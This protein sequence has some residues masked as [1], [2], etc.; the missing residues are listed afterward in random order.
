MSAPSLPDIDRFLAERRAQAQVERFGAFDAV[1]LS[2]LA[3]VPEWTESLASQ[4]KLLGDDSRALLDRL[5]G[6]DLIE[7]RETLRA[8]GQREQAFWVRSS[9]RMPLGRFLRDTRGTAVESDL[10]DLAAAIGRLDV[11]ASG[12]APWVEVVTEHRADPSGISLVRRVDRLAAAGDFGQAAELV[13]AARAVGEVTGGPLADAARRARWRIDRATRTAVDLRHLESYVPRAAFESAIDEVVLS[14][15]DPWALHLRGSGGVGKTMLVRYLACDRYARERELEPF[16]VARVDFDYLDPRYPEDRPGELLIALA[17][18][19]L[20]FGDTRTVGNAYRIFRD[21]VAELH[22]E[23]S[24]SQ[25]HDDHADDLLEQAI[26]AFARILHA[27]R[28]PSV[29]VLDTCEELTK[30]Y[31]PG[32]VAPAIDRTFWIL[33][34]LRVQ[35]D[36]L[37]VILAGRHWLTPPDDPARRAAGPLLRPR[38]YLRVVEVGG[39]DRKEAQAYIDLRERAHGARAGLD[40]PTAGRRLSPATRAVLLERAQLVHG[41]G[42]FNPFELASYCEWALTDPD[43]LGAVELGSSTQDPLVE[44]RVIGRISDDAVRQGAPIAAE[45]GRFDVDL[46]APAMARLHLDPEAIFAGLA[47]CEWVNVIAIGA[48]GRPSVLE[49]DEHLKD[50]I[51]AVTAR[52][53]SFPRV[54]RWQLGRDAANV[55]LAKRD[56]AATEVVEAAIRL[57][58]LKEADSFWRQV[59][60]NVAEDRAWGWA[61]NIAARAAAAEAQRADTAGAKTRTILGSILALE[62]AARMRLGRRDEVGALWDSVREVAGRHPDPTVAAELS[63][64]AVMGRIAAA[65][66]SAA[67]RL[68][69]WLAAAPKRSVLAALEGQLARAESPSPALVVWL[70]ALGTGEDL[71]LAAAEGLAETVVLLQQGRFDDAALTADDAMEVAGAATDQPETAWPDWEPPRRLLDRCR[72]ARLAVADRRGESVDRA[73]LAHWRDEALPHTNDV[74]AERLVSLCLRLELGQAMMDPNTLERIEASSFY[75]AD[76]RPT[77]WAHRCASPLGIEV[78]TAWGVLGDPLRAAALLRTYREAAVDAGDDADTVT[79]AELA[80]IALCRKYRTLRFLPSIRRLAR[81]GSPDVRAEAWFVLTLVEGMRPASPEEAGSWHAWWRCQDL[82]SLAKG[83]M[84]PP[85]EY[86]AP[87]RIATQDLFEYASLLG[88]FG[89]PDSMPS[90]EL[91][92]QPPSWLPGDHEEADARVTAPPAGSRG[93][94]L[95]ELGEEL[96]LRFPE[97]ASVILDRAAGC[98]RRAG[99]LRGSAQAGVLAGLAAIR[100]GREPSPSVGERTLALEPVVT[101]EGWEGWATRV[102][103]VRSHGRAFSL[104]K[105]SGSPEL[106][107]VAATSLSGRRNRLRLKTT[108]SLSRVL[109]AA[110]DNLT[111]LTSGLLLAVAS[112]PLGSYLWPGHD[113]PLTLVVALVSMVTG[114]SLS[115]IPWGDLS[116]SVG[117]ARS[118]RILATDR[119]TATLTADRHGGLWAFAKGSGLSARW[120]RAFGRKVRW[121]V[122][123]PVA[124]GEVIKPIGLRLPARPGT[125]SLVVVEL[126]VDPR[127]ESVSWEQRLGPGAPPVLRQSLLWI[128]RVPGRPRATDPKGWRHGAST[129]RGP[130]PLGPAVVLAKRAGRRARPARTPASRVIHLIGTP[131]RTAAGW[132]FRVGFTGLA[133][134][135]GSRRTAEGEELID[136][137]AL[138]LDQ[139][140]LLV[141]QAEPV[142]GLPQPFGHLREGFISLARVAV[143][144]GVIQAIVVPPL[145]DEA[146]AMVVET[147]WRRF[148]T[149]RIVPG[150]LGALALQSQIKR[151]VSERQTSDEKGAAVFDVVQF[152][153][154]HTANE[155][156]RDRERDVR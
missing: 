26:A 104:P 31:A 148:A 137:D 43:F 127:L 109:A 99:D 125:R 36:G 50:R 47:A 5:E 149:R 154:S 133:E 37:R 134:T 54:D 117:T 76:R 147:V 32:A 142:D 18:E 77:A 49:V 94:R 51:R 71:R 89:L 93:R 90:A 135:Q 22:E 84:P 15:G 65:G 75:A 39:F 45:L 111:P 19:L 97:Q 152:R 91:P 63:A 38:D 98:L 101:R 16:P 21:M 9:V 105:L 72:L 118:I 74:D 131:L 95:S 115:L 80:C 124:S 57:L 68:P 136:F 88:G 126:D 123:V 79:Q 146:A 121:T 8:G 2:R 145:P 66:S 140:T 112:V 85:P 13:A 67:G 25:A 132:R 151:I 10:T 129:Y 30:L 29:L 11:A 28:P 83:G 92:G 107:L 56:R 3:L 86:D 12:F 17:G 41:E 81:E 64:R 34:R 20:G 46:I 35:A 69:R 24:R 156:R 62:A 87:D 139:T 14:S 48:D 7:R 144:S 61:V 1:T 138:S 113:W 70:P 23:R 119:S 155:K 33:E 143:E 27:L 52:D 153:R 103:A 42:E 141:L 120:L 116:Y 73:Q 53:G 55:V 59:E 96:A 40:L 128:R 102:A 108:T 110:S 122:E 106:N 82:W 150:A 58:P 4:V 100:A 60:A 78:G 6:A 44:Q 114:W 130:G